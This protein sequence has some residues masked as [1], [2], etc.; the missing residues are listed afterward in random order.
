MQLV[1]KIMAGL[2]SLAVI[3]GACF[4]FVGCNAVKGN[5]YAYKT[6]AFTI[7]T[8][9]EDET[10]AGTEEAVIKTTRTLSAREFYLYAKE[11]KTLEELAT[12]TT[13]A[14]DEEILKWCEAQMNAM[15][16]DAQEGLKEAKETKLKFR[17]SK[18]EMIRETEPDKFTGDKSRGVTTGKYTVKNGLIEVVVDNTLDVQPDGVAN[19]T[20]QYFNVV[21]ENV[22]KQIKVLTDAEDYAAEELYMVSIVFAEV[23]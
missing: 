17:S 6:L 21:G 7:I 14:T 11:G 23:K 16:S 4:A 10:K 22:E 2:V 8:E 13:E 18:L 1:K 12:A 5:E 3:A 19:Y 9:L 15:G 20:I